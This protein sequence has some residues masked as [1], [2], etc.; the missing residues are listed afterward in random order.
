MGN[1]NDAIKRL[2]LIDPLS[3]STPP[4]S[5]PDRDDS[6]QKTADPARP[7]YVL[8]SRQLAA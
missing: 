3:E 5:T 6:R 2:G 1:F 4:Q 7:P 8:A